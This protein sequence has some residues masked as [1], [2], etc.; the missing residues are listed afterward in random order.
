MDNNVH[1]ISDE[2]IDRFIATFIMTLGLIMLIAPLWILAFPGGLIQRLGV[3][4]AFIVL[5]VA[6]VS[7]TTVAKP[8]ESLAAAAAYVDS[9]FTLVL[10]E[11]QRPGLCD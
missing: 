5:F 6:L 7:V 2:K 11:L 3:I 4:S 8:F 9:Y 10:S 1:Y